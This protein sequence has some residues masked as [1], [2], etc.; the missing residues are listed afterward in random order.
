MGAWDGFNRKA[1]LEAEKRNRLPEGKFLYGLPHEAQDPC[2]DCPVKRW[3]HV[4]CQ[5]RLWW[6]DHGME[7]IRRRILE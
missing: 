4:P 5:M 6:W 3:C 1:A 2:M 7:R